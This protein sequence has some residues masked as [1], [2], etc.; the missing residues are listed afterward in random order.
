M[1]KPWRTIGDEVHH[2]Q[3]GFGVVTQDTRLDELDSS[4]A[5]TVVNFDT[6]D[7]DICT[8]VYNCDLT[9]AEFKR[10]RDSAEIHIQGTF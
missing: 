10:W 1:K 3:L 4:I 5:W 6:R 7:R 8:E 2:E 9:T